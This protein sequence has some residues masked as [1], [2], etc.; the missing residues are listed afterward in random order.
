MIVN[1]AAVKEKSEKL[2]VAPTMK[3]KMKARKRKRKLQRKKKF[4]VVRIKTMMTPRRIWKKIIMKNQGLI[5]MVATEARAPTQ[6]L[7]VPS[8]KRRR[9]LI[10]TVSTTA[11]CSTKEKQNLLSIY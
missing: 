1:S 4:L 2:N 7:R 5:A 6:M 3:V 11:R 8:M 9:Q 10:M